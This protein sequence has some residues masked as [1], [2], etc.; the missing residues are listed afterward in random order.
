MF[1]LPENQNKGRVEKPTKLPDVTIAELEALLTFFYDGY[2]F[3]NS[4]RTRSVNMNSH[5]RMHTLPQDWKFWSDL[6]SIS[7][8]F[9]FDIIRQAS[10]H[11]VIVDSD[12]Y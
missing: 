10:H 8:R 1:R 3:S 5:T 2:V 4:Q 12:P 6:L 11:P 9:C 7:T